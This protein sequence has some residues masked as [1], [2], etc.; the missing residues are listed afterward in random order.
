[1]TASRRADEP[2][3][4][5]DKKKQYLSFQ[6]VFNVT[7]YLMFHVVLHVHVTASKDF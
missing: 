7:T 5:T 4:P 2:I 3:S 1:M 6:K